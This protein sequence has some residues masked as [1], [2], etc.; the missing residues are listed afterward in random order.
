MRE[1]AD[2][3]AA[4]VGEGRRGPRRGRQSVGSVEGRRGLVGPAQVGHAGHRHLA[5]KG[6]GASW[7]LH[8]VSLTVFCAGKE[9]EE[10]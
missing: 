5:S 6:M 2:V 7:T 9:R 8:F 10:K 1:M 3:R 4:E